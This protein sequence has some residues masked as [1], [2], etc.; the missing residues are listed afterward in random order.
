M[1]LGSSRLLRRAF[2]LTAAIDLKILAAPLPG[3]LG[4]Q[5]PWCKHSPYDRRAKPVLSLSDFSRVVFDPEDK[6]RQDTFLS[7]ILFRERGRK[8]PVEAMF[9]IC[10][11]IAVLPSIPG[12]NPNLVEVVRQAVAGI[13][14]QTKI[15]RYLLLHPF[16]DVGHLVQCEEGDETLA[17]GVLRDL[18]WAST[19][20][21]R[22]STQPTRL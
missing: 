18:E 16:V 9:A 5:F 1:K 4:G 10:G 11:L 13:G 20:T 2:G 15:L 3:R 19:S 6:Y 17:L 21:M 22:A 14:Q 8:D 7:E 12:E